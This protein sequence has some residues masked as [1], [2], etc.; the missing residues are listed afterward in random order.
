[1]ESFLVGGM[2]MGLWLVAFIW[3]G[4]A[5]A[6]CCWLEWQLILVAWQFFSKGSW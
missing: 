1:M 2:T 5:I 4:L 6:F 3:L